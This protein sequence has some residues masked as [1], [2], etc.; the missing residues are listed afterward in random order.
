MERQTPTL[1][2]WRAALSV[3]ALTNAEVWK[4][5]N[6]FQPGLEKFQEAMAFAADCE[7]W[8]PPV[9]LE[10]SRQLF[11]PRDESLPGGEY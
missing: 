8:G 4:T 7:P 6:G 10:D 2:A 3:A 9:P 5:C 11:G 1:S